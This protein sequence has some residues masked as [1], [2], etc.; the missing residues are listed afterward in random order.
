MRIILSFFSNTI[1]YVAVIWCDIKRYIRLNPD[2]TTFSE[3]K[4]I[5]QSRN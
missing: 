1:L 4:E 5:L 2:F 3:M